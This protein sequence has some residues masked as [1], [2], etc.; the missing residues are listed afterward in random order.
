LD[1][2][3]QIHTNLLLKIKSA[4]KVQ[5]GTTHGVKVI[6]RICGAGM[7]HI[8]SKILFE[9]RHVRVKIS[10]R[11]TGCGRGVETTFQLLYYW[12]HVTHIWVMTPYYSIQLY[13]CQGRIHIAHSM[14]MCPDYKNMHNIIYYVEFIYLL[15]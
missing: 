11:F 12:V 5:H 3:A 8:T 4:Y 14:G 13:H 9:W 2:L 1:G 15:F 10:P 7:V 6:G